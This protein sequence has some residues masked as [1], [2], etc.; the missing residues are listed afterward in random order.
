M[1]DTPIG[2]EVLV[3]ANSR[4][5]ASLGRPDRVPDVR[6]RMPG[7]TIRE[8]AEDETL[9][10]VVAGAMAEEEPPRVL[11]ILG[12]DGSVSRA[13]HLARRHDLTLLVLPNGTF[14]HFARSAGIPD[15]DAGLDAY[16]AANIRPVAVAEASVNGADPITV[17][18]A[19]SL[20]A[21]PEFLAER[22]RRTS[23]GKWWGGAVAAW[24]EMHDAHAVDIARGGK[25]ASVWSVFAGVGPND[26]D[27]IATMQ[28]ATLD[29]PVID[30]RVHHA[31][32]TRARAIASL[33]FGEKTVTIL[34][35]LRVMPPASDIERILD[36]DFEIEVRAGSAPDIWVHD[37][38]LEEVGQDGFR[39][40]VRAVPEGLRVYLPARE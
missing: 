10:D 16:A 4:S 38:E 28:R 13:A 40:R 7:A 25:R 22:E 36:E 1:S 11:A 8:L 35:A 3:V 34:R 18:N 37:G 14:N 32:G 26:P 2:R 20:G 9:D 12:G 33:A 19:V 31:R 6:R 23:L 5:G 24:R 30:V 21:Y 39:L 29:E 17:L 27:R 15:V